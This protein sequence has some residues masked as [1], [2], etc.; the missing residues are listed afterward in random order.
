MNPDFNFHFW[1]VE[2]YVE[3]DKNIRISYTGFNNNGCL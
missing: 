2:D 3:T 1:S